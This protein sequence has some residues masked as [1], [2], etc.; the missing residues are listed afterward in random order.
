[1]SSKSSNPE[2]RSGF[3]SPSSKSGRLPV[4]DP[5]R[6]LAAFAV[7]WFHLTNGNAMLREADPAESLLRASGTHLYLG[8]EVFFVISGFV[9]PYAMWRGRY[10]LRDYGRFLM[11]R[12]LRLEPPYLTT[13]AITVGLLIA[14]QFAPGFKGEPFMLEWKHLLL[15]FG[16]LNA[17]FGFGWY[18]PVFW[19]LAI[20]FQFY[21][22][23]AL[24][25]PLV[26]HHSVYV[27]AS[28]PLALAMLALLPVPG[29]PSPHRSG[30]PARR[31]Q[32]RR[33][34]KSCGNNCLLST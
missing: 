6:G 30:K 3:A 8:V 33:R 18:N 34:A 22:L 20:E 25:F 14:G 29:S 11:K 23:I 17:L 32:P 16:Y 27:R 26:K 28:V 21:L 13:L 5:L 24:L 9:L 2:A 1:M 15:H 7:M 31:W 19:T 4:L 10:R 12:L